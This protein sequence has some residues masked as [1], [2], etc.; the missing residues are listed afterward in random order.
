VLPSNIRAI[1]TAYQFT[2]GTVRFAAVFGP[3]GW[4]KSTLLAHTAQKFE[5]RPECRLIHSSALD[6]LAAGGSAGEADVLILDDVQ[7]ACKTLRHRQR[8]RQ[9]IERRVRL[10]RPTLLGFSQHRPDRVSRE[11]LSPRRFW[12][13]V[14][15]NEPSVD[16]RVRIILQLAGEEGLCIHPS[17]AQ[18][19]AIRL[20][21]NGRSIRGALKRLRFAKADW[22]REEDLIPACG[23][24]L[25]HL[26]G[27][28]GWDLRDVL[29]EAV[30]DT[31]SQQGLDCPKL[32]DRVFC[33]MAMNEMGLPE[34]E[35]AAFMK[36]AP[37]RVYRQAASAK[38][39]M[40]SSNQAEIAT[41][42]K[43]A[44]MARLQLV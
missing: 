4:G 30:G 15:I 12:S 8:F 34:D 17:I 28:D 31:L 43:S 39:S 10:R 18:V 6:W 26:G 33:W 37:S 3:S 23:V 9:A 41:A 13:T 2:D 42:C 32:R 5:A 7:D 40:E 24:L 27:P 21:G 19:A 25:P 20:C 36:S 44:A 22:S 1:E 29:F 11:L 16:D 38:R 35:I 14:S